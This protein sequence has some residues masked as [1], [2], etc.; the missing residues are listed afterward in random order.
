MVKVRSPEIEQLR[1]IPAREPGQIIERAMRAYNP[2]KAFVMFSGGKDSTV[3]LDL[4]WRQ[5]SKII[6]GVIHVYT[7]IAAPSTPGAR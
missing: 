7:T 2:D 4:L 6:S 1:I 3:T 5:F